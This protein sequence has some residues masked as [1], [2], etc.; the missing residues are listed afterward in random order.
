MEFK[1]ILVLFPLG[2]FLYGLISEL[3]LIKWPRHIPFIFFTSLV[4]SVVVPLFFF[5][6]GVLIYSIFYIMISFIGVFLGN[7][8]LKIYKKIFPHNKSH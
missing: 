2:F 4:L 8:F 7:A 6:S 1:L 3:V 5:E